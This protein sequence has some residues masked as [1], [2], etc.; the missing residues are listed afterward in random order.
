MVAA[1]EYLDAHCQAIICGRRRTETSPAVQQSLRRHDRSPPAMARGSGA[2]VMTDKPLADNVVGFPISA[3]ERARRLRDE[4]ERL[5]GQSPT[6]WRYYLEQGEIAKKH[7]VETAALKEMI[8]ATV[9]AAEKKAR[10]DKAEDRQREQRAEKQ[11]TA[12]RRDEERR[13]REQ[14]RAQ[15]KADKEAEKR[16]RERDREFA[17]LI[18]LPRAQHE[19]RLVALAERL[20]EDLEFLREQF[21][22]FFASVEETSSD[23]ADYVEPWPEP[24]ETKALLTDVMAQLKRYVVIHDDACAVAIVLWAIYAWVHEIGV[25]STFL[26]FSS[27]D[28]DS[29]KTTL[30]GVLQRLTPRAYAAAEL[31]G[32]NLYRFVDHLHPTL[33]ID[34]ADRL[35]ERRPDLV[36]IINVSWTRGTKIPRQVRGTTYFFD[37][38]CPKIISG[39]CLSL[40]KET[41]TRTITVRV[42]PK[43]PHE[44]VDA[45]KHVDDD[46]FISLRRKLTRWA[47]DNAAALAAARPVMPGLNNRVAMNWELLLAIA[48][49]AGGDW[50]ERARKAAVTLWRE[51]HEPS[52]GKRLLAAFYDQFANYGPMLP[53]ADFRRRLIDDEDGEWAEHN[54]HGPITKRQIAVLLDAY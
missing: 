34:D 53:S 35:L 18:R 24:V 29:G 16:Q 54:G 10:E 14:E 11:R 4:V 9:R 8:E 39:V 48:D 2:A 6:E 20:G 26:V 7:G 50:P 38:F 15:Q 17:T 22:L 5:A 42:L 46:E 12:A 45:F 52:K 25:H 21:G 44:K 23:D 33:I 13:H 47:A 41:Q 37:P 51:R 40:P 31:T 32:P 19:P 36:H 3:E 43:L 28:A 1:G 30:C 49:L 27:A